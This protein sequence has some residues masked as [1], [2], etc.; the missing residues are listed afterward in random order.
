MLHDISPG[1]SPQKRTPLATVTTNITIMLQLIKYKQHVWPSYLIDCENS[2]ELFFNFHD[3]LSVYDGL[4]VKGS[5]IIIPE[6]L[7][8]NILK[9]LHRANQ[10]ST[11]TLARAKINVFWPGITKNITYM[12]DGCDICQENCGSNM[13]FQSYQQIDATKPMQYV[14]IDMCFSHWQ[15]ILVLTDC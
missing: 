11:K 3:E 7:R 14:G 1:V 12:I 10:G 8:P 5:R 13:V 9:C 2:T 15:D 4:L 6:E